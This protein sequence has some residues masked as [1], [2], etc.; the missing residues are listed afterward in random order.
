MKHNWHSYTKLV[1]ANFDQCLHSSENSGRVTTE[2][3]KEIT[4]LDT[5]NYPGELCQARSY[6]IV[7]DWGILS[8]IDWSS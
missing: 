7:F 1:Y 8:K 3:Y 6:G 4:I 2:T 5:L